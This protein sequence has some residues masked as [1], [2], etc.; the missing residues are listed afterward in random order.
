MEIIHYIKKELM[1][2]GMDD[3]ILHFY[4]TEG[5]QL[6]FVNNEVVKT[7]SE[8]TSNIGIFTTKDKKIIST[9]LKDISKEKADELIKKIVNFSKNIPPN[10]DYNGIAKGPFN[11]KTNF[12]YDKNIM[13]VDESD[14]LE[15]A[16]NKALEN[17]KRVAGNLE[18]WNLKTKILTSS[19]AEAEESSSNL[20]FSLRAFNKKDESGHMTC[21]SNTLRDF[22]IE[23]TAERAAEIAKLAKNPIEAKSGRYP[24]IFSHMAFAPLLNNT[25]EAASVYNVESGFSFL[26]ELNK[27]YGNFTLEDD[28]TLPKG[29]NSTSFDE[30]GVPTQRTKIIDKGILKTYLHNTSTSKKYK[31]KT[32]ANAGLISPS[33]FNIVFDCDKGDIFDVKEGIYITNVWYTRFQN[34][35]DG[36]FSTIPRDGAFIVKNGEITQ[37]IKGLRISDNML[38]ILKNIQSC[39]KKVIQ[40][41]SWE[42]DIPTFTPEVLVNNVNITKPTH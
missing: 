20:Y 28:A 23:K 32:T 31:T 17:S 24:V 34:Y 38:N 40:T 39:N 22:E 16:I 3:V 10:K 35:A 1:N 41:K 12:E 19:G 37:S 26:Q 7:G 15:K 29:F 8:L 33:P 42:A 11:Y 18:L 9:S 27:N 6:K 30:E 2:K 21:C 5:R 36:D 13:D 25:S 4:E 14:L